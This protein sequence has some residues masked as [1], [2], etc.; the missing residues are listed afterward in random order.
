MKQM[1]ANKWASLNDLQRI[2]ITMLCFALVT[3]TLWFT[4]GTIKNWYDNRQYDK[5]KK[6]VDQ[7][8]Q[9]EL[10]AASEALE[11]ADRLE[12]DIRLLQDEQI[13]LKSQL[14][15][16]KTQL[17]EEHAKTSQLQTK[18]TQNRSRVFVSR[19]D[20]ASLADNALRS[21]SAAA[22]KAINNK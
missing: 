21:D 8:T 17:E 10:K 1:L 7:K 16:I 11:K 20:P 14:D 9:Q 22:G 6:E 18:Y 5:Q 12:T 2:V 15:Q 4:I 19:N 3:L 13:Q